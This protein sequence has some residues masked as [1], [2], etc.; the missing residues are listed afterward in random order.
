MFCSE[1]NLDGLSFVRLDS[2]ILSSHS[3]LQFMYV[4]SF[5]DATIGYLS[6]ERATVSSVKVPEVKIKI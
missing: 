2:P 5:E 6:T 3:D 1:C 4:W